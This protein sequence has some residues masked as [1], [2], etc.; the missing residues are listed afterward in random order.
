MPTSLGRDESHVHMSPN[1]HSNT[2]QE[3][4]RIR[5]AIRPGYLIS[6]TAEDVTKDLPLTGWQVTYLSHRL[7]SNYH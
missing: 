6:L 5:P 2:S 7:T 4:H 1:Q 3:V